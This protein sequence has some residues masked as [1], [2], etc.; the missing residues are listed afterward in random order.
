MEKRTAEKDIKMKNTEKLMGC[1]GN[2][3]EKQREDVARMAFYFA[4]GVVAA[5]MQVGGEK[6]G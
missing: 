1:L 4:Q 3:P 2:L 5:G 6:V